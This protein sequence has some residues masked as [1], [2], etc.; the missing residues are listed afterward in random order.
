MLTV[1]CDNMDRLICVE[2]RR[3]GLP[4]GFKSVLYDCARAMSDRP[5]V[6]AAAELLNVSPAKVGIVTGAAVPDH[7]PVGENDGPFGAVVLGEALTRIGHAVSIFTD[8][9]C[10]TP[11]QHLVDRRELDIEVVSLPFND[12]NEQERIA[13]AQDILVAIER[14][15]GNANGSLHGIN[16]T[17]RDAFRCNVDH[18][19]RTH[20][21]LGRRSVAIGDGGNEL[22]FGNIQERLV[23]DVPELA[24]LEK[25]GST[26][27]IFSTV[28][29]DVLVVANT[30]NVGA[31]GVAAALSVLREDLSL[32][33]TPEEETALHH[34]GVGLGLADGAT[35][36][37]IAVCDGVPAAA[38][39][40]V[41]LLLRNI[42]ER[43]LAPPLVREF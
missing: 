11:I 29:T 6:Q 34:V 30:S 13:N 43:A 15:G 20:A 21:G 16:G 32:C 19:F 25:T 40:A 22:G 8:G 7:M 5:L 23:A 35:G 24:Q 26:S 2:M 38:N 33:H 37:R 27:G 12:R 39:A 4:V 18:L 9:S 3:K 14:L 31:Y 1:A 28:E 10:A 41:V 36:R 17:C 42:A